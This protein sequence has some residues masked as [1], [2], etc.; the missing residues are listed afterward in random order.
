MSGTLPG[1]VMRAHPR[2][3]GEH[4]CE[5]TGHF[6][7]RGSSPL[8]RGTLVSQAGR[9][10]L[11]GLIPARA[12]NT[13]R[14]LLVRARGRAHPRSRGEHRRPGCSA[15]QG[16]GSSPLARGTRGNLSRAA[17]RNGLIPARAGNTTVPDPAKITD[18]AH[19]R[20]RGEH[21][22][23]EHLPALLLGSSPL[24]RGTHDD[25]RESGGAAG[26]IPARAGNTSAFVFHTHR[27]GAHPRSRGEH[28]LSETSTPPRGGAHPRSR[29]E[30]I[31]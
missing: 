28:T 4:W 6:V 31:R 8:A 16:L 1:W 25:D 3:R 21:H 17:A 29:G 26:L 20:S 18:R 14:P 13:A 23:M 10:G 7:P 15:V 30:H 2:S 22:I 24:A 5:V 19:P 11:W 12:G 27:V 9:I